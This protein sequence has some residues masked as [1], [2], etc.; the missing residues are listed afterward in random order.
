MKHYTAVIPMRA[1]S[2]GCPGKNERI[3]SGKPLYQHT[4]DQARSS[5]FSDIVIT[6]DIESLTSQRLNDDIKILQRPPHLALDETTMDAVLSHFVDSPLCGTDKIIL[7]QVTSPL[8]QI[9]DIRKAVALFET[10]RFDLVL[11]ASKAERGVLKYGLS[12]GNEFLPLISAGHCFSNRA[13]LPP[14]YRP[15]GGIFIFGKNWFRGTRSLGAGC[16]G[17]IES[18]FQPQMDIDTEEDF[19]AAEELFEAGKAE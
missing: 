13:E 4:L 15:D 18:S 12:R 1:G 3:F 10:G 9:E 7:L 17:F 2:K 5:G 8:R 19:R 14:V 6:T 11:S 16:I